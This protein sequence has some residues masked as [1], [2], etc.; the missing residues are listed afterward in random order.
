MSTIGENR[1]RIYELL[2]SH[3]LYEVINE[4]EEINVLILGNGWVGIEAFKAA[5]WCGQYPNTRLNITIGVENPAEYEAILKEK[6][7]GLNDF[8]K[9]HEDEMPK[10]CYANIKIK[11]VSYQEI[12][13]SGLSEDELGPNGLNV[14]EQGYIIISVGNSFADHYNVASIAEVM[15]AYAQAFVFSEPSEENADNRIHFLVGNSDTTVRDRLMQFA[16]SI[17]FMYEM[18]GKH[19]RANRKEVDKA[20]DES[21]ANEFFN[22]I[23]SSENIDASISNFLGRPYNCDSSLANAVH[24]KYKYHF[25]DEWGTEEEQIMAMNTAI[26]SRGRQRIASEVCLL[27]E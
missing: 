23:N 17:N 7:P 25:C 11:K 10:H 2:Y 1:L 9:F 22:S 16:K 3:P 24:E 19:N 20:F 15:P 12:T 5:F 26:R 4:K 13:D 21:F 6:L 8:A 18:Q 27:S 14:A